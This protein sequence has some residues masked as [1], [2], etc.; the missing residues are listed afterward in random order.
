M[1]LQP[2]DQFA[3]TLSGEVHT[4]IHT[5]TSKRVVM[6]EDVLFGDFPEANQM[7]E[8]AGE[9]KRHT[10]SHLDEYLEQAERNLT[11]NDP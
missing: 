3:K 7:R 10:I 1:K 9:L 2:I 5:A 6:R 4:S 11:S 8:W